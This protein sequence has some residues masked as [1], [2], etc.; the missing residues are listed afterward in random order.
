MFSNPE[1]R[2]TRKELKAMKEKIEFMKKKVNP[3]KAN[4]PSQRQTENIK[5]SS[6]Q[7]SLCMCV[8]ASVYG[9]LWM[10]TEVYGGVWRC[11]DACESVWI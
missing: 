4:I 6:D 5:G 2:G 10:H 9:C 11:M 8:R 1:H 3:E 7:K